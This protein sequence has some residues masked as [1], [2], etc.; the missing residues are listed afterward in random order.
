ML[1]RDPV[2]DNATCGERRASLRH[3]SKVSPIGTS[4]GPANGRHMESTSMSAPAFFTCD[5]MLRECP[6]SP[7]LSAS[8]ASSRIAAVAP[9][10]SG[11]P[12]TSTAMVGSMYTAALIMTPAS[13]G[14]PLRSLDS[15]QRARRAY[16]RDRH[17]RGMRW[18]TSSSIVLNIESSSI[19]KLPGSS[20]AAASLSPSLPGGPRPS[21]TWDINSSTRVSSSS[22]HSSHGSGRAPPPLATARSAGA[23][24][25]SAEQMKV[26]ERIALLLSFASSPGSTALSAATSASGPVTQTPPAIGMVCV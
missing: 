7:P 26:M 25:L 19:R 21:S 14:M 4:A 8:A 20:R 13:R 24:A 3:S 10:S 15:S 22:D 1:R 16:E 9:S 11:F 12:T 2:L 23:H 17:A 18:K 5:R 6:P